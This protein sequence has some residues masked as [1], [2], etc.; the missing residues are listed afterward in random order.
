MVSFSLLRASFW[1]TN[2]L[3]GVSWRSGVSSTTSTLSGLGDEVQRGPVNGHV[4]VDTRRTV[5][6]SGVMVALMAGLTRSV[7]GLLLKMG[8]RKT[9]AA[10][11]LDRLCHLFAIGQLVEASGV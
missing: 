9:E 1:N 11:L 2:Y 7:Q 5:A 4:W 8:S 3:E 6:P 10:N